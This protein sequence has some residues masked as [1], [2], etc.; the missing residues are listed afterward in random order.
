MGF[1][2]DFIKRRLAKSD[3]SIAQQID[4]EE[5]SDMDKA[6]RLLR[7]ATALKETNIELAIEKIKESISLGSESYNKLASYLLCSGRAY[8]AIAVYKDIYIPNIKR[9]GMPY[10]AL[11]D[12]YRKLASLYYRSK[13]LDEYFYYTSLSCFYVITHGLGLNDI[14]LLD[15]FYE[16]K[17]PIYYSGQPNF[18]RALKKIGKSDIYDEFEKAFM[19]LFDNLKEQIYIAAKTDTFHGTTPQKIIDQRFSVFTEDFFSDFYKKNLLIL[20]K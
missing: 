8:E 3:Y 12:A 9:A 4:I 16:S 19:P 11:G 13:N 1:L 10:H 6:A 14:E 18:E 15:S 5:E 7:E 2:I 17:R 20:L